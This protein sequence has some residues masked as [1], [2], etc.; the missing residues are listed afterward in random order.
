M[1]I[2]GITPKGLWRRCR[3][4]FGS[5][6]IIAMDR[7]PINLLHN[8]T[9]IC[10]ASL[11]VVLAISASS[12][13]A[14][15]P[16]HSDRQVMATHVAANQPTSLRQKSG[17]Q[18]VNSPTTNS[19]R[20]VN[21]LRPVKK[22]SLI[23]QAAHSEV[24]EE[25]PAR[26]V[27]RTPMPNANHVQQASY[28]CSCGQ[29][30]GEPTCGYEE[31]VQ[32]AGCG[33]EGCSFA[34]CDGGCES[35]CNSEGFLNEASCGLETFGAGGCDAC[36]SPSCDGA[37]GTSC[38]TDRYNFCL[39][40]FRI[41]W[42]RFEF[43]AGVNSFTGPANF[44]NQAATPVDSR[45]GSGSF[46]F[47]EGSNQGFSLKR[48][49]G[50]DLSSQFGTRATQSSLAGTEFTNETRN[51]IFVTGGLFRR[52]DFGLQYGLVVDYLNDDWWFHN[53]LVQLRGELS[54]N[55]GCD[56]EFGY[57]FMSG[58]NDS[59]SGTSVINAAGTNFLSTV[60]F[61]STDQHRL[62]FRG[63]MGGGGQYFAFAGTTDNRDGL[64]G[65][66]VST[67]PRNGLAFQAGT[68]YLIPHEG[69]TAGRNEN[70][71]W[72]LSMGVIYR[73][74]GRQACGRYCRPMF[75]VADNGTF[76]VDRR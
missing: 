56:H 74:G 1:L 42:C 7:M 5:Q 26:L 34:G 67:A 21:R 53:D 32:E 28:G 22:T 25:V 38:C 14:A 61:T 76:M 68:A 63:S 41:N 69:R 17:V 43:F 8:A 10:T 40:I 31:Y 52:V 64:L 6:G 59:T 39:P 65:A 11:W 24:I 46:G 18:Q 37:C 35:G 9:S 57:Q 13:F 49:F 19:S 62:F 33:A 30:T 2:F 54:W 29:C 75:D 48:L 73:P 71:S 15:P 60:S 50:L 27:K 47:Y 20:P 36:G 72:N 66:G 3:D 55:D 58:V 45:N 16:A 23:S 12:I 4:C 44:A 51:Q 70:E